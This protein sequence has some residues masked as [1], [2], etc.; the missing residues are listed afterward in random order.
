MGSWTFSLDL[1]WRRKYLSL[2][3]GRSMGF[4]TQFSPK[5][6]SL[7]IFLSHAMNFC[8]HLIYCL[9]DMV[10]RMFS[11]WYLSY[12]CVSQISGGRILAQHSVTQQVCS[13]WTSWAFS[14]ANWRKQKHVLI[15]LINSFK[16]CKCMTKCL[17]NKTAVFNH[18]LKVLSCEEQCSHRHKSM[19]FLENNDQVYYRK[20][21]SFF[22][23][24][25]APCTPLHD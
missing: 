1:R 6:S 7:L 23:I 15:N 25:S 3:V 4:I 17:K 24:Q 19:S 2:C 20:G 18:T 10:L 11:L 14:S 9:I 22:I 13:G 12:W 21:P 5:I 16:F 8:M